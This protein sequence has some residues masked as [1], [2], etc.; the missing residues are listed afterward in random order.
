ME[1]LLDPPTLAAIFA[2]LL[3]VANY[4]ATAHLEYNTRIFTKVKTRER[5]RR[6]GERERER[7]GEWGMVVER[8]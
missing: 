6:E 2:S 8:M 3:H 1:K 7:V 5:G 4:N